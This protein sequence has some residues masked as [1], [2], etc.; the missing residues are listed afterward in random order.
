MG[1][2]AVSREREEGGLAILFGSGDPKETAAFSGIIRELGCAFQCEPSVAGLETR[3]QASA[4]DAVIMDI[5][6][7]AVENRD[8][9]RLS[10]AH[11]GT[12]ILCLSRK[13]LHPE[14]GES[15][16]NHVFA[17]LTKPVD[18][19]ELGYWLRCIRTDGAGGASPV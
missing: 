13:R 9:R 5:D 7:L 17:C 3:L 12:P 10:S 15:I 18:P 6:S 4:F 2:K 8:L 16:R 19:D 11:P 14:L 1:A